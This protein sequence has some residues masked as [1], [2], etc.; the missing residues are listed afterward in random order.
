MFGQ[1]LCGQRR[2]ILA[3]QV[4]KG[5]IAAL[6]D[7]PVEAEIGFQIVGA[8]AVAR[9]DVGVG[10]HQPGGKP[11]LPPLERPDRLAEKHERRMAAPRPQIENLLPDGLVVIF[12][13]VVATEEDHHV[14][15]SD[16]GDQQPVDRAQQPRPSAARPWRLPVGRAQQLQFIGCCTQFGADLSQVGIGEEIAFHAQPAAH[17][18]PQPVDRHQPHHRRAVIVETVEGVQADGPHHA[19]FAAA[20]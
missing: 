9:E 20:R 8:P 5:E 13:Q 3:R 11:V 2:F 18:A 17:L 14:I 4:G 10:E 12:R 16:V 1:R 15:A 7:L 6:F 19:P